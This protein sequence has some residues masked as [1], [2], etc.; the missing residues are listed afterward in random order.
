MRATHI[1]D[2]SYSDPDRIVRLAADFPDMKLIIA[3]MAAMSRDAITEIG[4]RDNLYLET[5]IFGTTMSMKMLCKSL[6]ADKII[7][8]SDAPYSDQEIEILKVKK[9]EISASEKRKILSGNARR[10]IRI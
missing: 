6:G 4:K 3:H 9:A 10:V 5:S 2:P 1:V 8:G 7:Y